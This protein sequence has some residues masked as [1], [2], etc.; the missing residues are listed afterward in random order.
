M[1]DAW[2]LTSWLSI[3]SG[4]SFSCGAGER[5]WRRQV[6]PPSEVKGVEFGRHL[7]RDPV[8]EP[9]VRRASKQPVVKEDV[10]AGVFHGQRGRFTHWRLTFQS[11][12]DKMG[13]YS[14][15]ATE[16]GRFTAESTY[17]Q[18]ISDRNAERM[19]HTTS[20]TGSYHL[21]RPNTIRNEDWVLVMTDVIQRETDYGRHRSL[22]QRTVLNEAFIV[23][24]ED[25]SDHGRGAA[26]L[27][28][29]WA[30]IGS[31]LWSALTQVRFRRPRDLPSPPE[32]RKTRSGL[33]GRSQPIL[34]DL[35]ARS[36]RRERLSE[37][38]PQAQRPAAKIRRWRTGWGR[39]ASRFGKPRWRLY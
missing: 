31:S 2:K 26:S 39:P 15:D 11:D 24:F 36:V 22:E 18:P 4:S 7:D 6:V 28:L 33:Q 10:L 30:N 14:E 25:D 38:M 29:E 32:Q 20:A 9:V 37:V 13:S 27:R 5:V 8:G 16:F 17:S 1:A 23:T 19:A 34:A 12:V 3:R 35:P 21:Y